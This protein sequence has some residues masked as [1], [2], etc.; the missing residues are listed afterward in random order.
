MTATIHRLPGQ[1]RIERETAPNLLRPAKAAAYL[2][3]SRSKLYALLRE[4]EIAS[5]LMSPRCRVIPR[6]ECDDY[7]RRIHEQAIATP[8]HQQTRRA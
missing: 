4:D 7:L 6:A 5:T 2:G 1:P 8:Y 3:I